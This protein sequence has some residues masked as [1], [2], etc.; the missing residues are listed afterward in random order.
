MPIYIP[1]IPF[2]DQNLSMTDGWYERPTGTLATTLLKPVGQANPYVRFGYG[3]QKMFYNTQGQLSGSIN[4]DTINEKLLQHYSILKM[5]PYVRHYGAVI[6]PDRI[7]PS[8]SAVQEEGGEETTEFVGGGGEGG[9]L[10]GVQHLWAPP[11][12][13]DLLKIPG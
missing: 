5:V 11:L 2:L 12:D 4:A 1:L 8:H 6:V 3:P 13:G 10:K 7:V 9:N